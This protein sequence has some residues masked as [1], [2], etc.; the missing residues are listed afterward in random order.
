MNVNQAIRR[1]IRGKTYTKLKFVKNDQMAIQ[2]T[3]L[4]I[5]KA[6][7]QI[8]IGWTLLELKIMQGQD[9]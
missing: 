5:K 2:I 3:Q 4:G 7:V 9:R 6:Y 1:V 8:P